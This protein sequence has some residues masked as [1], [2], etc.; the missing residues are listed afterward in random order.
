MSKTRLT[1]DAAAGTAVTDTTP[2]LAYDAAGS[3]HLVWLRNSWSA[4]DAQTVRAVSVEGGFLGFRLSR[5]ANGHLALVWQAMQDSGA[6]LAYSIYDAVAST[7]EADQ[8]LMSN[9]SVEA[10]HSPAFGA[11]GNLYLAY[12][13]IAA[14]LVTQT[15]QISPTLTMTVTNLPQR[16]QSDLAFLAHTV[17]R[18]LAFDSLTALPANPVPGQSVTLTAADIGV[19]Q[20]TFRNQGYVTATNVTVEARQAAVTGTL[21]ASGTA[22]LIA[23]G[24]SVSLTVALVPGRYTL[25]VKADPAGVIAETDESNNLA[26]STLT[27]YSKIYLPVVLRQ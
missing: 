18:D 3:L 10:A 5:A 26:V 11:D 7:W 4:D 23:P 8:P 25:F 6:N 2:S 20:I 16:G 17:G 27:V 1:N 15:I 12:Q 13:K 21:V 9:S 14:N 24:A 19:G 22:A